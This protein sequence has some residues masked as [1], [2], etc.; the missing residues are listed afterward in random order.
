MDKDEVA[1]H[2]FYAGNTPENAVQFQAA[3]D[4]LKTSSHAA[5]LI[6]GSDKL[7]GLP[8]AEEALNTAIDHC[9]NSAPS[10]VLNYRD[11]YANRPDADKVTEHAL[12]KCAELTP[13]LLATY[14]DLLAGKPYEEAVLKQMFQKLIAAKEAGYASDHLDL[15]AGKPYEK[16]IA[17]QVYI[18][19]G[20]KPDAFISNQLLEKIANKPYADEVTQAL[21]ESA[22]QHGNA[23]T[24]LWQ[25]DF[26]KNKSYGPALIDEAMH[27]L[28]LQGETTF[29]N[30]LELFEDAQGKIKPEKLADVQRAFK[31]AAGSDHLDPVMEH[32]DLLQ[33]LPNKA[34]VFANMAVTETGAGGLN[35]YLNDHHEDPDI[36]RFAVL[37]ELGP[38]QKFNMITLDRYDIYT[39]TYQGVLTSMLDDLHKSGKPLTDV[40]SAEQ[41]QHMDTFLE[42][43]ASYN[44]INDVIKVIP[45]DK[46]PGMI[47]QLAENTAHS[48]E[49][50]YGYTLSTMMV[51]LRG[52]P[53]LRGELEAEIER[54]YRE[55]EKRGDQKAQD[56]FGLIASAYEGNDPTVV[57]K[58]HQAFFKA[59]HDDPRYHLPDVTKLLHD[60]LVDKQGVCN[61]LMVFAEDQDSQDSYANFKRTY[62]G[63]P[64]WKIE[65]KGSFIE[66]ETTGKTGTPVHIF[67]NK[68]DHHDDG[69][70]A[71]NQ[72]VAKQQG[73]TE[74]SFQV[75][76]GR[77]HSTHADD[78]LKLVKS[79]MHLVDLGSCGG[80]QNLE[81]VWEKSPEA[82]LISTQQVGSM[83]VNDPLLLSINKQI[84]ALGEV[85]WKEQQTYLDHLNHEYNQ[86]YL[87]PNRNIPI[88]LLQQYM[89]LHPSDEAGHERTATPEQPT[90]QTT[91]PDKKD[92]D[93]KEEKNTAPTAGQQPTT[94]PHAPASDK[95]PAPST[96]T[97]SADAALVKKNDFA[98]IDL[99]GL[100]L[101]KNLAHQHAGT[102]ALT[103]AP[104]NGGIAQQRAAAGVT[105]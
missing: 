49:L 65:D 63:K 79:D 12:E 68:P 64:G 1:L 92:P 17:E 27:A 83:T 74:P 73:A 84:H 18:A 20:Q 101:V 69:L 58:E 19:Y 104:G 31:V 90:P 88:M 45:P 9:V 15:V 3:V 28:A 85:H 4:Y 95:Q 25:D 43:A 89:K 23:R 75:F 30:H 52:N 37:K 59:M 80:Y 99:S 6:S 14:T 26:L 61:Q 51:S 102:E 16:E 7:K 41:L 40:L 57:T 91:A 50:T 76:I 60:K 105:T 5:A 103:A 24:V 38:A 34:V 55:A 87:L 62:S 33:T 72:A 29:F 86:S 53:P 67:A 22:V 97:P 54:Q 70:T 42:A 82:Q 48:E 93:K 81:R 47:H 94:D 56:K 46:L 36:T 11:L 78:Y 100:N 13:T 39:S 8:N 10:L 77:G 35:A 32:W 2:N 98:G 96:G 66:V 44:R 71:I 21:F